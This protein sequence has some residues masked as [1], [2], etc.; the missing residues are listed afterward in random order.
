MH[1]SERCWRSGFVDV[2]YQFEEFPFYSWFVECFLIKEF[3]I[4]FICCWI[5]FASILLRIIAS[6][7]IKNVDPYPSFLCLCLVSVRG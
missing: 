3:M 5:S 1:H 6:M 4:F 2:L 7:F